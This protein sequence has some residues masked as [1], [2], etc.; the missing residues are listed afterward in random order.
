MRRITSLSM[1]IM[2]GRNYM[3]NITFLGLLFSVFCISAQIGDKGVLLTEVNGGVSVYQLE[4]SQ[5]FRKSQAASA[6][7]G[8]SLS[9]NFHKRV[10]LGIEFENHFYADD[11]PD[12]V[13]LDNFSALRIGIGTQFHAISKKHFALSFGMT[14]GVFNLNYSRSTA[15]NNSEINATGIYQNF[16]VLGRFYFGENGRFGCFVKGGLINNPMTYK[17]FEFNGDRIERINGIAVEDYRVSSTGFHASFGLTY[18]WRI[19]KS[20][21]SEN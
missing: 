20:L 3:K 14:V 21:N 19:K 10:G 1:M 2:V 12:S 18:N 8:A 5:D 11:L 17:S 6:N 13:N 7:F 16:H 15:I 4:S 9:Y